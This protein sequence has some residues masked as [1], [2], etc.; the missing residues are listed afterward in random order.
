VK[1]GA[2]IGA[3]AAVICGNTVVNMKRRKAG[4]GRF[5][6]AGMQFSK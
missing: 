2:G 4:F 5:T 1:K 6:E 3:N